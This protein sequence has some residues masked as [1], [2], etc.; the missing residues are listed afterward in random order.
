MLDHWLSDWKY[1]QGSVVLF[2]C[3]A[4][5]L[6]TACCFFRADESALDRQMTALIPPTGGLSDFSCNNLLA[7][8]QSQRDNKPR[9]SA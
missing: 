7:N 1:Q 5:S 2:F 4:A 3:I 8:I 9:L 6:G